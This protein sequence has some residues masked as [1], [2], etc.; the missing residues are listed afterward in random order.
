M[1]E[2]YVACINIYSEYLKTPTFIFL[3]CNFLYFPSLMTPHKKP[4][5]P[6]CSE[7]MTFPKKIALKYNLSCIIRKDDIYF[8]P[9][10]DLIV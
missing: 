8:S 9:K 10:Y 6:K 7:K 4:F 2:K 5:F 3:V 1:L